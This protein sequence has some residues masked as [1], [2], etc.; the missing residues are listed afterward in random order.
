MFKSFN[1]NFDLD[2]F[3]DFFIPYMSSTCFVYGYL[4]LL[5]YALETIS[6]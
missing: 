5:A 3:L 6:K 1:E 4:L 2:L